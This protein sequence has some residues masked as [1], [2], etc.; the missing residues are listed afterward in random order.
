MIIPTEEE[1]QMALV[2]Y[3]ELK[4]LTF[5]AVPNSTFTRSW[6]QKAKNKRTGL[7][8]GFPDMIIVLPNK[9]LMC[10]LKRK[11]GGVLSQYQKSSI[12]TLNNISDSVEAIVCKGAN[13]CIDYIENYLK[14]IN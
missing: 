8:R 6:K 3:L 13:E 5:T 12:N 9:L 10:E 1:E 14:N 7:R 11:K 2:E 4:G